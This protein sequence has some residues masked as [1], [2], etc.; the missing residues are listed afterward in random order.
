MKATSSDTA[1]IPN[2]S[3]SYSSPGETGTLSFTPV[4]N[5]FGAATITVK[6]S[7]GQAGNNFVER[8]FTV[9]VNPVNDPPTLNAIGNRT[10]NEDAPEQKVSLGGISGGPKESDVLIVTPFSENTELIPND[11]D[12]LSVS[13]SAR[14]RPDTCTSSRRRTPTVRR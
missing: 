3:V 11:P 12:H 1:L 13:Y 14:T 10:I 4:A 9:T 6:V 8:T 5:A 7:D 2:P